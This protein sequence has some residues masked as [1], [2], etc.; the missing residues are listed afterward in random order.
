MVSIPIVLIG[1]M[2]LFM[3]KILIQNIVIKVILLFDVQILNVFIGLTIYAMFSIVVVVVLVEIIK[4]INLIV[5]Y[6]HA[7]PI[8]I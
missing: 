4:S 5:L 1:Q 3:A 8:I 7:I 6:S 2:K